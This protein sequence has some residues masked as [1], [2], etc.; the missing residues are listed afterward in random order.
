MTKRLDSIDTQLL[1]D[2][3]LAVSTETTRIDA[4][5]SEMEAAI[6]A[7]VS[8]VSSQTAARVQHHD[9]ATPVEIAPN[10]TAQAS[11]DTWR[12]AARARHPEQPQPERDV[13]RNL[14]TS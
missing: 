14:Q 4:K 13:A 9:V 6:F 5:I 2:I 7:I 3:P 11:N 12:E 1:N 8:E 10:P